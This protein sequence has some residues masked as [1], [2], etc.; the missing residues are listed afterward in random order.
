MFYEAR[1][2]SAPLLDLEDTQNAFWLN[3][4]RNKKTTQG[5]FVLIAW[6]RGCLC[7]CVHVT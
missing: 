3:V 7:F 1:N 5:T 4:N 2:A 6:E